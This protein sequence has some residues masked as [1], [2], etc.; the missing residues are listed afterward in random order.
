MEVCLTDIPSLSSPSPSLSPPAGVSTIRFFLFFRR[1]RFFLVGDGVSGNIS[2][3]PCK[4]NK[5]IAGFDFSDDC[6]RIGCLMD[7]EGSV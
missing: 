3:R 1:L 6:F 5:G 4:F 2:G 7:G